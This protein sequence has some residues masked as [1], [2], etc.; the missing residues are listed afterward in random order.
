[1]RGCGYSVVPRPCCLVVSCFSLTE[2]LGCFIESYN[3][4]ARWGNAYGI[5][6]GFNYMVGERVQ[7]DVAAMWMFVIRSN[8]GL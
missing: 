4:L 1:M 7:L 5:D 2:R 8:V 3:N 6:F